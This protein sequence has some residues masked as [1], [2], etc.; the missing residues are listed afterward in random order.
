MF[1]DAISYF[2]KDKSNRKPYWAIVLT[3]RALRMLIRSTTNRKTY[4]HRKLI[5]IN[6]FFTGLNEGSVNS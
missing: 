4:I 1:F 2:S 3:T 6:L 5:L